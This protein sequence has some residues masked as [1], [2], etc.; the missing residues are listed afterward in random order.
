MNTTKQIPSEPRKYC[1]NCYITKGARTCNECKEYVCINNYC[2]V[3]YQ[4]NVEQFY[5]ICRKCNNSIN[6][7]L[8]RIQINESD[9]IN[10][11]RI[12]N[13][14]QNLHKLSEMREMIEKMSSK[15]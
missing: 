4:K 3:F 5:T 13:D 2:G 14:L 1:N 9:I 15:H 8:H 6:N 10:V 11:K 12:D 7:K